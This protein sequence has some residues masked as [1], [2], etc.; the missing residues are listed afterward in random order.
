MCDC[1]GARILPQMI[2][3]GMAIRVKNCAGLST[4]FI[5]EEDWHNADPAKL[6]HREYF[7][8]ADQDSPER[9]KI[10]DAE[11]V[12]HVKSLTRQFF[13]AVF[14]EPFREDKNNSAWERYANRL[15][16]NGVRAET[17]STS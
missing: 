1:T 2:R 6:V 8:L 10:I 16:D 11:R 17:G 4:T 5:A 9:A 7:H 13:E 3:K 15:Y 12:L 14:Q